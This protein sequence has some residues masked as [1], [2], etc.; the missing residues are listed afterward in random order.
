MLKV[1]NGLIE[2]LRPVPILQIHE[3]QHAADNSKQAYRVVRP[4]CVAGGRHLV[5]ECGVPENKATLACRIVHGAL[6]SSPDEKKKIK[7]YKP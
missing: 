3:Y 5:T 2:S 1:K 4:T 7:N 6:R